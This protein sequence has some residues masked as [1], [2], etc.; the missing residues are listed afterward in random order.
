MGHFK[1]LYLF[2]RLTCGAIETETVAAAPFAP[3]LD[4]AAVPLDEAAAAAAAALLQ[5]QELDAGAA[6]SQ[7][8]FIVRPIL[9]ERTKK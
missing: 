7:E 8:R 1:I 2:E 9:V 6:A 5:L 4:E 3:P